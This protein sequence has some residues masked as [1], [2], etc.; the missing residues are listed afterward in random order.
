[1]WL[2]ITVEWPSPVFFLSCLFISYS[3]LCSLRLVH[4]RFPNVLG[5]PA[6]P[7]NSAGITSWHS[8]NNTGFDF[9]TQLK[10]SCKSVRQWSLFPSISFS[11]FSSFRLAPSAEFSV[12]E[13]CE[14]IWGQLIKATGL[15]TEAGLMRAFTGQPRMPPLRFLNHT[16]V[17]A[18][19]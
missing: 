18:S 11:F 13:G 16:S 4:S 7:V 1:M 5:H 10:S 15:R 12:P 6:P 14:P 19:E 2:Y 9:T 17:M 3:H 8:W